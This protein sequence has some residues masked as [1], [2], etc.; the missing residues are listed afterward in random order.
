[1]KSALYV[2]RPGADGDRGRY[3]I[4]V[5]TGSDSN[6]EPLIVE[7]ECSWRAK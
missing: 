3:V 6:Q 5:A 1:M 4:A 7:E 2:D